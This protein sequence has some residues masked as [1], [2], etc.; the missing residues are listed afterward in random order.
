MVRVGQRPLYRFG[1]VGLV[2]AE[3]ADGAAHAHPGAHELLGR[4][5]AQADAHLL[6]GGFGD[7]GE[8]VDLVQRLDVDREDAF[9]HGAPQLVV[10]LGRPGKHDVFRL[11]P[12][13]PRYDQLSR[14]GDF[15]SRQLFTRY[16]LAH[17]E[18]RVRLDGVGDLYV[19][20]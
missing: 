16:E 13:G 8:A 3:L 5:D 4:V 18:V 17:G 12:G 11:E 7:G 2:E 14:R 19:A 9:L 10:G 1:E 20:A 6:A 15:C